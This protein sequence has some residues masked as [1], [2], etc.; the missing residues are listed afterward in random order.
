MID[1]SQKVYIVGNTGQVE[2]QVIARNTEQVCV[3]YPL[4]CGSTM[5][6]MHID[7]VFNAPDTRTPNEILNDFILEDDRCDG[8]A[9][10]KVRQYH[11]HLVKLG[12]IND[13]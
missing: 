10:A 5:Q 4:P 7:D 11:Q 13:Q 2:V 1:F 8:T 12:V 3:Q 9:A 6:L